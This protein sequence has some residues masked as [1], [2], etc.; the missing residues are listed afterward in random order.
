MHEH[1]L[2]VNGSKD[3]EV[4]RGEKQVLPPSTPPNI[5]LPFSTGT[6]I[7][8]KPHQAPQQAGHRVKQINR[9]HCCYE[10]GQNI[11]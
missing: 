11:L 1:M 6:V 7:F 4:F 3:T 9:A 5:Q 10:K 2:T 8:F